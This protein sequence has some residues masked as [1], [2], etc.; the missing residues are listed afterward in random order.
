VRDAALRRGSKSC[1]VWLSLW[2]RTTRMMSDDGFGEQGGGSGLTGR[3]DARQPG[4]CAVQ[5]V[6]VWGVQRSPVRRSLSFPRSNRTQPH[7][8]CR[9]AQQRSSSAGRPQRRLPPQQS[10]ETGRTVHAR[11]P[12]PAS[13]SLLDAAQQQ[14]SAA[15]S[16]SAPHVT[17]FNNHSSRINVS[18]TSVGASR[19]RSRLHRAAGGRSAARGRQQRRLLLGLA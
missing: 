1:A 7:Q 15:A 17:Q 16:S 12:S 10:L 13:R 9:A 5:A 6:C 11:R 4:R 8:P 14:Q 2:G 3:C 19:A 18:V